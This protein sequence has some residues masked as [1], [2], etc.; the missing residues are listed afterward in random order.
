MDKLNKT[1]PKFKLG[2]FVSA[3]DLKKYF[4]KRDE[5][6]W[7][8]ELY[9]ISVVKKDTN[10]KYRINDLVESYNESIVEKTKLTR[11]KNFWKHSKYLFTGFKI[12]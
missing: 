1:K 5:I 6:N 12:H 4:S 9:T 2:D 7:S 3:A 8:S 10:Q 11:K